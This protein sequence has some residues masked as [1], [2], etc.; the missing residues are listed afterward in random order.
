MTYDA[1]NPVV[2]ML[3]KAVAEVPGP[4]SVPGGLSYEPKWDGFRG[5]VYARR[6]EAG[7]DGGPALEIEIG[8]R[9]SK[10]L[11]RY[12][13]E[14]VAALA[15]LLPG[16]CVLDGEIVV[17]SGEPGRE[18]LDWEALGQ[19]IHP[20]ASRIATLSVETPAQF[21]AFDLLSLGER[22]LVDA[23]F[24]ERRALLVETEVHRCT[25]AAPPTTSTS[26]AAGWRSSRAPD[27]TAWSRSP[28]TRRTPPASG[29][30]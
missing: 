9:G 22:D 7:A 14:L 12:F 13:P 6:R 10:T 18:R 23:P 24:A 30:C 20:A 17:R 11:T 2:P 26:P 21:V 16:P 1:E 5:I 15:E 27:W 29:P 25:S 3:A 8:S 28:S 4:D 19:R